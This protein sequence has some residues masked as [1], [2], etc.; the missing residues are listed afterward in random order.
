MQEKTARIT[1][2]TAIEGRMSIYEVAVLGIHPPQPFGI[3]SVREAM[4]VQNGSGSCG[5]G[6]MVATSQASDAMM[7]LILDASIPV[8]QMDMIEV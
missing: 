1:D 5:G 2:L 7:H 8:L 6:G 3:G 4:E